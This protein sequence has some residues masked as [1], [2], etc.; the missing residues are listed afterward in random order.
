MAGRS[1]NTVAA[2]K[3]EKIFTNNTGLPVVV[4]INAISA[5][6]TKNPK[7]SIVVDSEGDYPLNFLQTANTLAQNITYNTG[8]FDLLDDPKGSSILSVGAIGASKQ[9]M[10]YNGNL[11]NISSSADQGFRYQIFEPYFLEN[12]AA[13]NKATAYGGFM[14]SSNTYRFHTDLAAD[15][16]FFADWLQTTYTNTGTTYIDSTSVSYYN[17]AAICDPWTDVFMSVH[18]NGY[19]TAGHFY[20]FNGVSN[21]SVGSSNVTSNSF[22]YNYGHTSSGD[23]DNYAAN[24][25]LTLDFQSDGG[26]FVFGLHNS[27]SSSNS[28]NVQA[29]LGFI[30]ARRWRNNNNYTAGAT[31][32]LN[33]KDGTT[34]QGNGGL[35]YTGDNYHARLQLNH[36][37]GNSASWIKYNPTT[38]RYYL[39]IQGSDTERQGIWSFDHEDVFNSS[40]ERQ[41]D[42]ILTKEIATHD[43][44]QKT[45]QPQ[46]IGA[47]LWVC[48]TS[49]TKGDALYS[50]DLINWKTAAEHTGIANA[51][52]VAMDNSKTVPEQQFMVSG[53]SYNTKLNKTATGFSSIPQSG[54]LENGVGIGTFE[55]NGIVLNSGDNLYLENQ[56][57]A[58]SVFTTVTFVE[59]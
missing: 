59:V 54:L 2:G 33:A 35:V 46:R 25:G 43:L 53:A 44:T 24:D 58:T 12:P 9:A 19:M 11:V 51:V 45:T 48:F 7:C 32:I 21:V 20:N 4:A 50:T 40:S 57:D 37:T 10:T 26:V 1:S 5:D 18:H 27:I 14:P 39:N 38:D 13:Y 56:D 31:N 41:F 29:K 8:D 23:W 28:K 52:L 22:T 49:N 36:G 17:R 47:S 15:K 16:S 30:S 55:R 3:A 34:S 42:S 6:N